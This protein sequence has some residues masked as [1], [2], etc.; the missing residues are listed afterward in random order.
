MLLTV[1]SIKFGFGSIK[2]YVYVN[3]FK[4]IRKREIC[5]CIYVQKERKGASPIVAAV[6][7]VCIWRFVSSASEVFL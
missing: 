2:K 6:S 3:E 7:Y 4:L 1:H 5:S